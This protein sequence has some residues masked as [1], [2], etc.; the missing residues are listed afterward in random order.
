MNGRLGASGLC[1]GGG[2]LAV[3]AS[4]LL[5]GAESTGLRH[6][7]PGA[8]AFGIGREHVVVAQLTGAIEEIYLKN[9]SC[10]NRNAYLYADDNRKMGTF[11]IDLTRPPGRALFATAINDVLD[12]FDPAAVQ[13]DGF[14]K[15]QLI[16]GEDFGHSIQTFSSGMWRGNPTPDWYHYEGW[17][18]RWG[19]AN[20]N[21]NVHL[22]PNCL[23]KMQKEWRI[24]PEKR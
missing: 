7:D 2:N 5:F 10:E 18:L 1:R 23:I 13:Y 6:P 14:E 21:R 3:N 19:T 22:L 17:P 16:A 12:Q 20:C 8:V 15:L 11:L 9:A 24:A 4:D